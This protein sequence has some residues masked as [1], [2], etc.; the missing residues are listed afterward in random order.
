MEEV[1]DFNST[2]PAS[3]T[4]QKTQFYS[5]VCLSLSLSFFVCVSVCVCLCVYVC[6]YVCVCIHTQCVFVGTHAMVHKWMSEDNFVTSV[7]SLQ[8]F[9]LGSRAELRSPDMHSQGLYQLSHLDSPRHLF[10]RKMKLY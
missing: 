10:T 6:V 8:F 3:N 2:T 9:Y 5:P 4:K 7:L 1:Q